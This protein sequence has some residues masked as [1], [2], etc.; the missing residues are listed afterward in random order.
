MSK[1]NMIESTP[2]AT[3]FR[4]GEGVHWNFAVNDNRLPRDQRL[5]RLAIVGVAVIA[6]LIWL[7]MF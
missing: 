7:L 5:K 2:K 1:E 6:L 4:P 3:I